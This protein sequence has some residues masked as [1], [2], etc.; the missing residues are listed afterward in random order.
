[1]MSQSVDHCILPVVYIQV[2]VVDS[3]LTIYLQ[4]ALIN[5]FFGEETVFSSPNLLINLNSVLFSFCISEQNSV[6][7]QHCHLAF[8]L[9]ELRTLILSC[10]VTKLS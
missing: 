8:Y 9:V 2:D 10:N 1:M 4:D 5:C 3:N 6:L 7:G